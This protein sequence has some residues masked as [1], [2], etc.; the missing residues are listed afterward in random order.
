M[1]LLIKNLFEFDT[2]KGITLMTNE[3]SVNNEISWFN[4]MEI[5]DEISYLQKGELL[6]TT[7]YKLDNEE[8]NKDLIY[9][10]SLKGLAGMGIQTGY[11]LDEIPHYIIDDGNKY[12]FPIFKIPK[13]LSFSIISHVVLK[14]AYNMNIKFNF[15]FEKS[16]FI[17]ENLKKG[18]NLSANE[19]HQIVSSLKLSSTSTL[20]LFILCVSNAYDNLI[21]ESIMLNLT[22]KLRN[23][24][25]SQKILTIVE[26]SNDKILFLVSS[27]NILVPEN[28]TINLTDI[29][30]KFNETDRNLILLMGGSTPFKNINNLVSSYKEAYS[31]LITLEKIKAKTGLC[32]YSYLGLFKSLGLI[33]S[34]KYAASFL[35]EKINILIEYDKLHKTNYFYTLKCYLN[36]HCNINTTSEKI[37]IH[38][39]TLRNRLE[40][41]K[42]LCNINFDDYF[43]KLSISLGIY[44]HDLFS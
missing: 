16:K 2:L 14:N 4:I 39:H 28:L 44:L 5:L 6:L 1:S 43:S 25:H 40:K 26:I 7:G 10:L 33:N 18:K 30:K 21:P 34:D 42:E 37:Y 15:E 27:E 35:Q 24:F 19:K 38:R 13:D 41:I 32:F 11:Y 29:L 31:S 8:L 23:Y 17:F 3:D 12:N 22:N 20:G 36:N 9:R